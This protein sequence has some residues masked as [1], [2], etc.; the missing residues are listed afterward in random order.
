MNTK[1][2]MELITPEAVQN[3]AKKNYNT[4]VAHCEARKIKPMVFQEFLKN[5]AV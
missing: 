3:F 2:L 4:Y 5:Y 1:S